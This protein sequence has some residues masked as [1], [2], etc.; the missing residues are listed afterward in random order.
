MVI[1]Q[2]VG[3]YG[4]E[5][6]LV[7]KPL[8]DYPDRFQRTRKVVVKRGESVL[9]ETAVSRVKLSPRKVLVWTEAVKDREKALT[10]VGCEVAVE[11][12]QAVPIPEGH[13][14]IFEIV[15]MRVQTVDG[16]YVGRVKEVLKLPANDVFVVEGAES[17]RDILIPAI[18]QVVTAVDVRGKTMTI[19]PMPGLLEDEQH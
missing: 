1:G 7:I 16:R 17:R 14:Y 11:R 13:Y 9:F 18:K 12:S 6:G 8:T 3:A 2:V 4:V 5:G 19:L 15:G 10:L